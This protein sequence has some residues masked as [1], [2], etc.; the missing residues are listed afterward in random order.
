MADG[1]AVAPA[2][3]SQHHLRGI[4]FVVGAALFWS[5]GGLWIKL[6]EMNGLAVAGGRSA[7]AALLV[8]AYMRGARPRMTR[9]LLLGAV[10]YAG[11]VI[12]FVL[13][14]KNTTAA[15]AILIQYTAPIYVALLS[16]R[17]LRE[18]TGAL[19]W[20]TIVVVI[21]GMVLLMLDGLASGGLFGNILALVSGIFFAL[22]VIA[23]RIGRS[24]SAI[25]MVL[26]GN[27][28]TALIGLPFAVATP[29]DATDLLYL[30]LL[31]VVQLGLGYILFV[32]GLKSVSAIE[33][34]L[35]PVIEPVLNPVWVAVFAAEQPS[36]DTII[37][38]LLI[39]GAVTVRSLTRARKL[40]S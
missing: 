6:V 22:C 18:R 10:A 7:I 34:A 28:L 20:I 40:P 12:F 36:V 13:A 26:Y 30:S 37:G 11:T 23:I 3:S 4:L 21:V 8:W 16:S 29:P 19:D 15:N 24:G 9:E 39:V 2:H 33:G 1:S 38:G 25:G 32:E 17:M 14:T 35:L 27:I 5:F 31:G